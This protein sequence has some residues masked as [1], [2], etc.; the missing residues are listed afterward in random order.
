ML[1]GLN[2]VTPGPLFQK[3]PSNAQS[4]LTDS[5]LIEFFYPVPRMPSNQEANRNCKTGSIY[6]FR[7]CMRLIIEITMLRTAND[8]ARSFRRAD[9]L[10]PALKIAR[11]I[12]TS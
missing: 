10:S 1:C 11:L 5:Q 9:Q 3:I 12:S 8:M 7:L 2:L 6:S 4:V